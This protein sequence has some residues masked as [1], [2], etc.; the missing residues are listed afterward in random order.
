MLILFTLYNRRDMMK[1]SHIV[2]C[3]CHQWPWRQ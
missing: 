1:A 2:P 3:S